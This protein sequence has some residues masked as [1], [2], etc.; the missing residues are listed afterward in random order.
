M[1]QTEK[2]F[3]KIVLV[4]ALTDFIGSLEASMIFGALPT[5]NRI[6]ADP[7]TTGWLITGFVLVQAVTAVIGGRLGDLYGRRRVLEAVL[8]ISVAGSLLSAESGLLPWIIGGRCLQGVSGAIVPLSLAILRDNGSA[9]QAAL[10]TGIV[11][12]AYAISGG[13][14][15]IL[16]GYFAD[17]G[18][19]NWIFY[20]SGILPCGAMLMNRFMIPAD[21][22]VVRT[23]QDVDI[24]GAAGIVVAVAA[25]MIG[26]S[27][28]RDSGWLSFAVLGPVGFGLVGLSLW[29]RYEMRRAGP[30]IQLRRLKERHYLFSLMTFFLIG[31]G[32][33]QMALITLS[34]MQQPKWTGVG[35]GL[36]GAMAGIAKLPSN[37]AGVLAGPVAGRIAQGHGGRVAGICGGLLLTSAWLFLYVEHHSLAMVIGCAAASTAALTVMFVATPAVIMEKTP[38]SE[39]GEATGF[40]Y[41]IRAVGMGVGTQVVSTLLGSA[42]VASGNH[43]SYS[44]PLAY[45][46][47]ILFVAATSFA[48]LL[49]T[50]VIPRTARSA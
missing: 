42:M 6:Y 31:C 48:A 25:I 40:A 9:R 24:L 23:A 37:L 39:T 36:T 4:L 32:G 44:A 8:W 46:R 47:A 12:G 22:P 30:V 16:G 38:A 21:N 14:G 11:L 34:M 26:L 45:E 28:S 49:L 10:G 2:A 13:L 18:H 3:F 35:L 43:G 41:L 29:A 27:M 15:F 50:W 17:I 5:V 7:A 33:Q 19:W 1:T 20:V